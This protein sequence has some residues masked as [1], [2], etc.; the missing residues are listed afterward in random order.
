MRFVDLTQP[1]GPATVLWPGSNS[2]EAIVGG[3]LPESSYWRD[4]RLP[5]H[6]G[7]HLDAPAHFAP[8]G[9]T[10]DQLPLASLVRPAAV[11]DGRA[12]CAGN[13]D[14]EITAEHVERFEREHGRLAAGDALIL[15]TG[16]DA[17]AAD[18]ERYSRFPGLS[19][20]AARLAVARHV[21]G[22]GIDTLGIEPRRAVDFPAHRITQ[23]AGI[24]HLEALVGLDRL[25]PRG[26][27]IVAGVLPLVDG[28]GGPAR[29]FAILPD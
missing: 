8:D 10:A 28:S 1:L 16:W 12:V 6:A 20:D 13:P 9:A 15:C 29:A 24:W 14:A 26:A 27:W 17:F 22:I 18:E 25:P 21:A 2:F 11:L 5:E 19:P 23:A 7:T 4:L 3:T